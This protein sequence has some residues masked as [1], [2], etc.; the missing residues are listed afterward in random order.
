MNSVRYILAS[1]LFFCLF[2]G[3]SAGNQKEE[4]IADSVRVALARAITDSSPPK[5]KFAKVDD[6]I[7][8][9]QWMGEMSFR[10]KKKIPDT[11]T[12]IEFLQTIWYEAKRAGLEPAMVL[13]L[14]QV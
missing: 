10:L 4:A 13:G 1:C 14:I 3:T 2:S 11:Q 7:H 5:P 12:R 6:Q 8:Y 9:L